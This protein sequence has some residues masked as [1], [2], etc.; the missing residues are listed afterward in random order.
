MGDFKGTK[1]RWIIK[2][3]TK[4]P[5]WNVVG[6]V[7]G[8]RHKIARCPYHVNESL[9]E[10]WNNKE[11]DEQKANAQ[12]ISKAPEM[13]EMLEE[14]V[15]DLSGENLSSAMNDTIKRAEQLIK[16]ATKL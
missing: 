6:T 7:L 16:Q 2:H 4:N 5:A 8:G 14:L 15:C 10:E 1:G 9:S 11:M 3:S 13:L 12:L